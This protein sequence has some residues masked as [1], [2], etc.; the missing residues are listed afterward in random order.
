MQVKIAFTNKNEVRDVIG[1]LMDICLGN[2]MGE[3]LI[4]KHELM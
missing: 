1:N 3:P 4:F 2:R